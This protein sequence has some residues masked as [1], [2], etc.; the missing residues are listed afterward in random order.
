V[1]SV[2]PPSYRFDIDIEEDLIEEIARVHGFENIP[3]LPPV[4]AQAMHISPENS[5][6][7]FVL[8]RQLA[9]LDYQEVVNFSFVDE[10]AEQDFSDNP[11]PIRLLNPIASQM[12]VMR[13]QLLSG[14]VANVRYNLNRKASR[15]RVFELGAVFRKDASIT[16]GPLSVAG[17]SQPTRVAA[18]AYGPVL[19]EQWGQPA[20]TVDFFDLKADLEA[21]FAPTSLR[22]EPLVHPALHPGRSANVLMDGEIVGYIGELHPRLQQKLDLP[23]APVMFDIDAVALGRRD[24]PVYREISRFPA[25]VRDVALLVKHAVSVQSLIDVFQSEAVSNPACRIM[26]HIVLFDE[27]R[28]KGLAEDEK[29]LAFRITMQDTESTLQDESVDAAMAAFVEAVQQK[30]GAILRK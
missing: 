7:P 17:I 15:V 20:R 9:D 22:F 4:A 6:S 23:L 25:V 21:L 26:Q 14:L 19:D 29:S 27:Y 8:R 10:E 5:R 16:D 24:L 12:S 2:T 28:G 13:S 18:L 1:F 30:F 11:D 3:A